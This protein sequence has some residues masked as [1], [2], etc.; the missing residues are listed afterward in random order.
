MLR[1]TQIQVLAAFVY[2]LG[3]AA[4]AHT[5]DLSLN[6]D[7]VAL[8]Y[9]TQIDKSELNVGAG[10]LHHQDKGDAYYGSL[11]VA[12]NVN[13]QSGILAGIGGRLYYLDSDK[14]NQSGTA[15]GLGGFVNWE[16]P[17]VTNLS[18]RSDFYYAPDV[19][20]FDE[21]ERYLDFTARVQY[22]IIEQA[23]VYVGYRNAEVKAEFGGK[24][25]IDEGGHLGLMIWF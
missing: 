2:L 3:S 9:N 19:L 1:K 5:L 10:L 13:K 11:F 20:A 17:S 21:I 22:R 25:T 4:Q 24:Q 6:N 14:S 12:D 16:I 18:I 23:W 15:L 7:A 8:D